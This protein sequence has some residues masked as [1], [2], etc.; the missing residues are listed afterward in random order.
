LVSDE[1]YS[2][3][4][5]G[6]L[7][8]DEIFAKTPIISQALSEQMVRHRVKRRV[9]SQMAPDKNVKVFY[10]FESIGSFTYI[11]TKKPTDISSSKRVISSKT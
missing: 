9:W 8:V 4:F 2:H 6:K 10:P 7:A 5:N 1:Q 11:P 3:F